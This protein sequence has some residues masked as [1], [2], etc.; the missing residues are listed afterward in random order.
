M[1]TQFPGIAVHHSKVCTP[2]PHLDQPH[3]LFCGGV[4]TRRRAMPTTDIAFDVPRISTFPLYISKLFKHLVG[5]HEAGEEDVLIC[6]LY[7]SQG[8]AMGFATSISP[9]ELRRLL[10]ETAGT[11]SSRY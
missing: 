8:F 3:I 7:Q 1:Q 9:W 4:I 2:T 5:H 6:Y 11:F 10:V